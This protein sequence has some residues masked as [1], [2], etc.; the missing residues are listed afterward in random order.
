M[1]CQLTPINHVWPRLLTSA[2]PL[3]KGCDILR[4]ANCTPGLDINLIHPGQQV[5]QASGFLYYHS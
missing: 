4:F 2:Q 5:A 1:P 3:G